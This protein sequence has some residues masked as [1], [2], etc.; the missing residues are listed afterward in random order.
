MTG[1]SG[2]AADPAGPAPTVQLL[3]LDGCPHWAVA[4]QRLLGA[5]RQ[6]GRDLRVDSLKVST[7]EEAELLGFRGSPTI[8]I[9]GDD[10]FPDEELPKGL[11]CRLY[12]T[13]DGVS[14]VPTT[15]Q[16]V[17]ALRLRL[18]RRGAWRG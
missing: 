18:D 15:E 9:D 3:Y 6:L 12:C 10:P 5:L 13:T 7:V 4:E 11:S 2:P 1:H 8:L 17:E 16:L 14:G